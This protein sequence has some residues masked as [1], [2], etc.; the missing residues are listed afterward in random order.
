MAMV[1]AMTGLR[2]FATLAT[3]KPLPMLM[4]LVAHLAAQAGAT[5]AAHESISPEVG[6]LERC[7]LASNLPV[8]TSKEDD[9]PR[10]LQC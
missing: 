1:V 2:S 7:E 4:V 8:L 6:Y 5:T 3:C 9:C 10:E